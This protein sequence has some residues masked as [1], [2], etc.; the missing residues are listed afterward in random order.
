MSK[1][2][3]K[4]TKTLKVASFLD[5]FEKDGVKKRIDIVDLFKEFG[6]IL[7]R[8]GRNYTGL[9]PFHDDK[10]P[11]LSVDKNKGLYNCFGCGESGDVFTLVEKFKGV[12]FKE[13]LSFLKT[14]AGRVKSVTNIKEAFTEKAKP[15]T[16]KIPEETKPVPFTELNLEKIKDYYHKRFYVSTKAINYL[17]GRGLINMEVL[18]RFEPGFAGGSIMEKVSNGQRERLK[19][20]GILRDSGREHFKNCITFPLTGFDGTTSGFYGRNINDKVEVKHLFLKGPHKGI[21]NRKASKV[22]DEIILCES[23]ID[24]LT[25][26]CKGM[27]NVQAV[28]GKNSLTEEHISILKA[29]RVKTI[30]LALDS[31][32]PGKEAAEKQSKRLLKESFQVKVIFPEKKDWNE[33]FLSFPD[34]KE[35]VK[36]QIAEAEIKQPE[37]RPEVK[38]TKSRGIYVFMITKISYRVLG[39]KKIF[40]SSLKVN[41]RAEYEGEKYLD[42]VDLYSARS[43]SSFS[44]NLSRLFNLELQRIEKDLVIIVEYFEKERD[45]EL[46]REGPETVPEL[47]E[48][49]KQIGMEFLKS[50]DMLDQVI[51]DL[52]LIGYVGEDLNKQLVYIAASSR[53]LDDPVSV[54]ILSQSAAGKSLLV[55]TV[56]KLIPG[57]DV[58]S[59]SS[60]SDQALNYMRE[61]GLLHKF[62]ILGEAV[63]SEV[64]EHQIREMLSGHEL[65]RMVTMKDQK[66]GQMETR[67]VKSKVIVSAVMSSTRYEVNPE[68]ASRCFI[69]NADESREQ[70]KRIH[71]AQNLKYTIKRYRE[72]KN[73]VPE[74]IIKHHAAQRLLKMR[75]IVNPY[76]GHLDFPDSLM[77]MRRDNERFIDLIACV[78]FLRQYQKKEKVTKDTDTG[79]EIFYIECDLTD[80]RIAYDILKGILPAT[81]SSLPKGALML[82]EE[83]RTMVRERAK[84]EKLKPAE[85]CFT[86]REIRDATGHNQMF[87]KRYLKLLLEY[88]YARSGGKAA[89]GSRQS[90]RLVKDEDIR[91]LDMSMILSPSLMEKRVRDDNT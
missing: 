75:I 84:A 17:K 21:F 68:N 37:D 31:D 88:E 23:I 57:E 51:S 27:E 58:V 12:G 42:N 25:L 22:Y 6:V 62:L 13:A 8:K 76:A 56:R 66:T 29:D 32:G 24:A 78:C 40:V 2:R 43:R 44:V 86:Q 26:I 73:L 67:I 89:R 61:G 11:S 47:T 54:L 87:V 36:K 74:I 7:S 48:E 19:V 16:N 53:K 71:R 69:I 90:Y 38:V 49:E 52:S 3:L 45:K 65:S 80:Y 5:E 81:T 72:K 83:V 15:V 14:K 9:C 33:H 77:R 91:E 18:K 34:A 39:V 55:D 20:L 59:V 46:Y 30:V 63:H 4:G 64:V 60:L 85:V 82:Y 1:D 50:K 41:I 79:E 28:C 10:K 70:T 35:I